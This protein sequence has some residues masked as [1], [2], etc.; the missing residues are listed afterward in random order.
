M[1]I[2]TNLIKEAG[3]VAGETALIQKVYYLSLEGMS[4]AIFI[5]LQLLRHIVWYLSY[6][7]LATKMLDSWNLS[8]L[9]D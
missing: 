3:E 2:Q 8:Y 4:P 6:L 7:N 5:A 9:R 1:C